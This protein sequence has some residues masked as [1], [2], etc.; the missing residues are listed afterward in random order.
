[1]NPDEIPKLDWAEIN[2]AEIFILN[3][4]LQWH[5]LGEGGAE[6]AD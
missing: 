2:R 4:F 3:D 5:L 6:G 1:M